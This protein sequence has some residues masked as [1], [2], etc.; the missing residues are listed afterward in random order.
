ML[1]RSNYLIGLLV[2]IFSVSIVNYKVA[3]AA[4]SKSET[5]A[6]VAPDYY[7]IGKVGTDKN[8][9]KWSYEL[10]SD[11]TISIWQYE[12]LS[13]KVEI[14][15]KIDGFTVSKIADYGI[16]GCTTIT[17]IK[18]PSTI[19][20]IGKFAFFGC[21]SLNDIEIP[22][23]VNEIHEDAFENTPWLTNQRKLNPLVIV[24]DILIDGRDA[25]G[26]IAIPSNVKVIGDEAFCYIDI[27]G[28]AKYQY[29]YGNSISITSVV[30]PNGVTKIGKG[31]F[32]NCVNIANIKIPFTVTEIDDYAF[33]GYR[34]KSID[35]PNKAV[36]IGED[37]CGP[38]SSAKINIGSSDG[39]N[40]NFKGQGW[41]KDEDKWY[42]LWSDG[43][44]RYGWY[45]EGDNWYYFYGNGQMATEFIDL[46]GYS[47][48][49]EPSSTDGK[50]VM[51]T[52]WKYIDGKW[53]Y[54]NPNSDG[55]KG[56]MK[57]ACWAYIDGYW[58]YFYYDGTM[59]YNTYIDGYYVNSNGAWVQ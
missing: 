23:S 9:I 45:N 53:F 1:K 24:N 43:S 32:D 50:A 36:K 26:D 3:L 40:Q 44:Y 22:E 52:G 33:G 30:I 8:N 11:G 34:G 38:T 13:G 46:G 39:E 5:T 54:F 57:R 58:Y 27:D 42:W 55:Y 56:L 20:C 21:T 17:G 7:G 25:T 19:K 6:Q 29:R 31:A 16:V 47:Y 35:I 37:I 10:C 41:Y 18:V 15:E 2:A 14:P 4:V 28:Q 12:D 59:A 51:L 49:F 48:Y